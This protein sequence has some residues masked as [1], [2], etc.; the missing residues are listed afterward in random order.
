MALCLLDNP[1][2]KT[3]PFCYC[4]CSMHGCKTG[5]KKIYQAKEICHKHKLLTVGLIMERN[6]AWVF[7]M[8]L[9]YLRWMYLY[10]DQSSESTW[11]WAHN[12]GYISIPM[13]QDLKWSGQ[14]RHHC[15]HVP[16][17][18]DD[19]REEARQ[20]PL[21]NMKNRA[22]WGYGRI[23]PDAQEKRPQGGQDGGGQGN[24]LKLKR[25]E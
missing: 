3:H 19:E 18:T 20:Q 1:S 11:N 24:G 8:S 21:Q 9:I 4:Q 12:T 17:S 13:L 10:F 23:D 7:L 15:G 16:V 14:N 5:M 6:Y 25:R 22:R 2:F